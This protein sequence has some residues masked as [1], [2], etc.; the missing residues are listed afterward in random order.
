M[1]ITHLS[2]V[3]RVYDTQTVSVCNSSCS[4]IPNRGRL[5]GQNPFTKKKNRCCM[6]TKT[7]LN[8]IQKF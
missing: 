1:P 6:Y 7:I 4:F 3:G 5:R 2:G 8:I